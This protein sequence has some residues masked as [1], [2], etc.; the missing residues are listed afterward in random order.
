MNSPDV[1][2][3]APPPSSSGGPPGADPRPA[4]FSLA[5]YLVGGHLLALAVYGFYRFQRT[6]G[7]YYFRAVIAGLLGLAMVLAGPLLA[8][9]IYFGTTFAGSM[10]LPGIP[11]SINQAVGAGVL[12]AWALWIIAGRTSWPGGGYVWL[13]VLSSIYFVANA[14]L[15][16]DFEAGLQFAKYI[17]L[18]E[19]LGFV[20]LTTL[21]RPAHW[22]FWF[23]MI[24]L[25]TFLNNLVGLAEF[26]TSLDFFPGGRWIITPLR[27]AR[28]NGLSQNAIMF[29]YNS[30]WA[31]APG[32][33]LALEDRTKWRRGIAAGLTAFAIVMALLTL[34][35]QTPFVIFAMLVAGVI[36]LKHRWMRPLTIA[37][38]IIAVLTA[39]VVVVK[40]GERL[41]RVGYAVKDPSYGLRRDK[42][43]ILL[44]MTRE[45]PLTG[46]GLGSFPTVW[47]E[48]MPDNLWMLQLYRPATHY[49]DL[50]YMQMLGESG[51][52]GVGLDLLIIIVGAR[53]VLRRRRKALRDGN[54]TVANLCSI[55]G[56]LMVHLIM[57]Q[58]IQ[59][60]FFFPRSWWLFAMIVV[61]SRYPDKRLA[62]AAAD[63]E[64]FVPVSAGTG[65]G[66]EAT[67][68]LPKGS[69]A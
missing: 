32:M 18:Y 26:V 30:V 49:P 24:L 23:W 42:M 57:K 1:S 6:L 28:I 10:V 43:R 52:I 58:F 67:A 36:M 47:S 44:Q 61:V 19:L 55:L 59:D 15:G 41:T 17:A 60:V 40:M 35:R 37:L 54:F 46:I 39:P 56:V 14:L 64:A 9:S 12:A 13:L 65:Q 68:A 63:A 4:P 34:N 31:V 2:T 48:Y 29:A 33:F 8:L 25:F 53:L 66:T 51:I 69:E 11:F 45:H 5:T 21:R 22:T 27:L 20:L 3:S 50:G 38:V 16:E 62:P 7:P